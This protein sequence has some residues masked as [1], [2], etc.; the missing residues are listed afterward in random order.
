MSQQSSTY[1]LSCVVTDYDGATFCL[2]LLTNV[3]VRSY[4]WA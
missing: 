1:F 3:T 4:D 2:P